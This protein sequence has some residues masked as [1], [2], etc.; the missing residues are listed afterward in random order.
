[1][2]ALVSHDAGG[3][4]ILASYVAQHHLECAF[5]LDGPA[6]KIFR[7]RFGVLESLRVEEAVARG[8]WLLAGTSWQSDIEWHAFGYARAAG[9]RSVAFLDHW[10]NFPDRFVRAGRTHLPDEIWVGDEMALRE[11]RA[12]FPGIPIELVPNPYFEDVRRD[13][14]ARN[15]AHPRSGTGLDILFVSEPLRE[16]GQRQFGNEL[17]WG[18]TEF[19]AL[20]YLLNHLELLGEPVRSVTVRP[21]PGE[22]PDKYDW[23]TEEFGVS[24]VPGGRR[25][26]FDEIANADVVAGCESMAMVVGL[27]AGRR[28]VCCIPPGGRPCS[29]PHAEIESLQ[30]LARARSAG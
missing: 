21:H 28:V 15:A 20:R 3:A 22:P 13:I 10:G 29:L 26:L 19:D 14:A 9:K 2:I 27:A 8:D 1:L 17:H 24:V 6:A 25:H 23:V 18:Y 5:A 4:E 11:A 16:H 12:C 7:H 30:A